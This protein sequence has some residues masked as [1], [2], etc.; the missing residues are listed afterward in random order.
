MA[1]LAWRLKP[2]PSHRRCVVD[3]SSLN[4]RVI[5]S[6]DFALV[7]M[8]ARYCPLRVVHPSCGVMEGKTGISQKAS[9]FRRTKLVCEWRNLSIGKFLIWLECRVRCVCAATADDDVHLTTVRC[10]PTKQT[11]V[12]QLLINE[13]EWNFPLL[14]SCRSDCCNGRGASSAFSVPQQLSYQVDCYNYLTLVCCTPI[15]LCGDFFHFTVSRRARMCR[16]CRRH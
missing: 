5:D 2:I 7:E 16:R 8:F 12:T 4:R 11:N 6:N 1:V 13:S 10:K 9:D 14:C 15:R 3:L